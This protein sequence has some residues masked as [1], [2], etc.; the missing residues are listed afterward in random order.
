MIRV[1]IPQGKVKSALSVLP[2][3]EVYIINKVMPKQKNTFGHS[4]ANREKNDN[5]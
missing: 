4:L 5:D 1:V 2:A 3:A